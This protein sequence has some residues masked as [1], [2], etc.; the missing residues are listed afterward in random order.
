MTSQPFEDYSKKE[1]LD[2]VFMMQRDEHRDEGYGNLA[3]CQFV[4]FLHDLW[5]RLAETGS[6]GDAQ[7]VMAGSFPDDRTAAALARKIS[8][9]IESFGLRPHNYQMCVIPHEAIIGRLE[10]ARGNF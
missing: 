8:S 2:I 6:D 7:R 4:E 5:T 10:T 9:V 3:A 1:L